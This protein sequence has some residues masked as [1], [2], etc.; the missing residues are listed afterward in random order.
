[1]VVGK[2]GVILYEIDLAEPEGAAA[3]RRSVRV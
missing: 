1:M 3:S 2:I